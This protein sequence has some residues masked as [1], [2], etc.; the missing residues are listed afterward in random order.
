MRVLI[1]ANIR[2]QQGGITTQIFE[3]KV[4]LESEGHEVRLVST[5]GRFI[6]RLKSPF[7]AYTESGKCDIILGVG[8]AYY[9]VIPMLVASVVSKLRRKDIIYNFHDGQVCDFIKKYSGLLRLF[10]GREKIIVATPFLEN[11]FRESGFNPVLI[12]NHFNNIIVH[13][14][15]RKSGNIKIMWAR[16]FEKL[17]RADVAL[18]GAKN[19]LKTVTAEF[20]F[21]GGG[22]QRD[23]Y[24][25]K[26]G[27][28]KGI[29][30]HDFMK[31]ENLLSEYKDYDIFI[32]TT[33]YDN[34]PMSI[35]EAGMNG[36]VVLTSNA[37]GTSSIY[38]DSEVFFFSKGDTEDFE[39][40]LGSLIADI[41]SY[42]YLRDNLEKKIMSFSWENVREKWLK[43]L[44]AG[45]ANPIKLD[46]NREND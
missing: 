24:L 21:Y 41:Q 33:D 36:L 27:E 44:N 30:F 32:N 25:R 38:N 6:E 15:E 22:S 14:K 40:K 34:F 11:V 23:Y 7:K 31:R 43:A 12:N 29:F 26:Y 16:S 28:V 8:C 9:G 20:H 46:S 18:E 3:L 5:H 17:Y 35:V 2:K 42:G 19:I 45:Q 4:S 37:A 13:R 39:S 1:I 10:F